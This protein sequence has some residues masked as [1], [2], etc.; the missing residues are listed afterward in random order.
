M[1]SWCEW[2]TSYPRHMKNHFYTRVGRVV[3][4]PLP[5][6]DREIRLA[7][8]RSL[9]IYVC[10]QRYHESNLFRTYVSA[11]HTLRLSYILVGSFAGLSHLWQT[12]ELNNSFLIGARIW[13]DFKLDFRTYGRC[14][15]LFSSRNHLCISFELMG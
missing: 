5:V 6:R 15:I 4:R 7:L 3:S 13:S 8:S 2:D 11:M 12:R 10:F 14:F 9:D 1:F